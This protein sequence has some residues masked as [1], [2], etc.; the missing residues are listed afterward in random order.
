MATQ[1]NILSHRNATMQNVSSY[2]LLYVQINSHLV[3][4]ETLGLLFPQNKTE[5]L[6]IDL[7]TKY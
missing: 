3:Y 7:S 1:H 6:S 4:M 2:R 5:L